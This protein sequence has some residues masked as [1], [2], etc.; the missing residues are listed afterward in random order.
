MTTKGWISQKYS[1]SRVAKYT[2]AFSTCYWEGVDV[3]WVTTNGQTSAIMRR[4][5]TLLGMVTVN[6]SEP[7]LDQVLWMMNPDKIADMAAVTK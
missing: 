2:A 7:G 3:Q 1:C 4:G 5:D 6:G